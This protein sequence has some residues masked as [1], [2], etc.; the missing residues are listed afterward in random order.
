MGWNQHRIAFSFC[1]LYTLSCHSPSP[2]PSLRAHTELEGQALEVELKLSRLQE[3]SVDH[4]NLLTT[5]A[6]DKETLSRSDCLKGREE[7]GV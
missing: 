7:G 1:H 5:M 2:Y 3:Q 6:Q 4:Q